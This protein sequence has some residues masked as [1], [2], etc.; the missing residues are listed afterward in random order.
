MTTTKHAVLHMVGLCTALLATSAYAE[1]LSPNLQLNGYATAGAAL[2]DDDQQGAYLSNIFGRTGIGDTANTSYDSVMG[3]Q[4][5]YQV[6]E[7]TQLVTQLV[8][9]GREEYDVGADWAYI[10]YRLNHQFTVRGGRFG[11]PIYMY[12]DT[13][14]IGQA[15]PWARLPV[16]IYSKLPVEN[17]QGLDLLYSQALGDWQLNAQ[18]I[19]GSSDSEIFKVKNMRGLV[20]G[21]NYDDLSL[22]ASRMD[23]EV[24]IDLNV[25]ALLRGPLT[26]AGLPSPALPCPALPSMPPLRPSRRPSI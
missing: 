1:S 26:E 23:V 24:D 2:L 8:A 3:L 16:E 19:L 20:L 12:S 15:Y 14:R 18:A 22:R 10:A 9:K 21:T 13:L 5:N 11:L 17:L 4:L 6:N 25:N 7:A